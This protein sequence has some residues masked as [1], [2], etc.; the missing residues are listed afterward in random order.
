MLPNQLSTT[1]S[2]PADGAPRAQL[3]VVART[4]QDLHNL[5]QTAASAVINDEVYRSHG[6]W[7]V[8]LDAVKATLAGLERTCESAIEAQ[9]AGVTGLIDTLVASATAEADAAAQQSRAQA[10]IEMAELQAE[11]ADLQTGVDGLKVDLQVERDRLQGI[12]KQL[13]IELGARGRA[14]SERDEARRE[15]QQV[16]LA[17]AS[18]AEGLRAECQAQKTELSLARQQLDAVRAERAKLMATFQSVQRALSLGQSGDMFLQT[19]DTGADLVRPA[20]SYLEDVRAENKPDTALGL[21]GLSSSP[22]DDALVALIEAHPEAVADVKQ[23]LEQVEAMYCADLNA[24]RSPMQVVDSLTGSLRYARDVIVARSGLDECE[25]KMLFEQ[26]IAVLLDLRAGT[27]FGRH[28][29][30]SAY[31]SRKPVASARGESATAQQTD[32]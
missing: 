2:A 20:E 4:T 12:N 31:T 24:G 32:A 30:I 9:E 26:Q 16:V 13:D 14:E 27:S 23:V 17:A 21:A 19:E 28:L 5:A 3:K 11:I 25:A 15:C 1:D 6:Q 10:L 18:Q 7:R 22:V 29:S 8:T